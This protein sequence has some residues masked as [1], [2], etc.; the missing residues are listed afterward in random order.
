[1]RIGVLMINIVL[2]GAIFKHLEAG[3]G[4]KGS[5]KALKLFGLIR[6]IL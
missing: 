1:M 2:G 4:V 6:L 5:K 3:H